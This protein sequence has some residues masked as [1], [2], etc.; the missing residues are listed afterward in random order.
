MIV[1]NNIN[2][3]HFEINGVQYAKIYQPLKQGDNAIGI[4][5]VNDTKQQLISGT[6]YDEFII[7]GVT[8]TN[9]EDTVEALLNLV[10]DFVLPS[11]V[12]AQI[13]DL[14]DSIDSININSIKTYQTLSDLNASTGNTLN[15]SAIVAN[16]STD[17]NNGYYGYN[18]SSWIKNADLYE[19]TID[20]SNTSKGVTGKAVTFFEDTIINKGNE[21][22]GNGVD[23][24]ADATWIDGILRDDGSITN[25]GGGFSF[26]TDEFYE[27]VPSVTRLKFR[28]F[29]SFVTEPVIYGYSKDKSVHAPLMVS[30]NDNNY[31]LTY[32]EIVPDWVYFVRFAT[33]T[34]SSCDFIEIQSNDDYNKSLF[35][36][37]ERRINRENY[38][39]LG[40]QKEHFRTD[41]STPIGTYLGTGFLPAKAG[42]KISYKGYG[43]SVV[44]CIGLFDENKTYI[45]TLLASSEKDTIYNLEIDKNDT[46]VAFIVASHHINGDP[47]DPF[48]IIESSITIDEE[49][50]KLKRDTF[51]TRFRDYY[52]DSEIVPF[53]GNSVVTEENGDTILSLNTDSVGAFAFLPLTPKQNTFSNFLTTVEIELTE[54]TGGSTDVLVETN[55]PQIDNDDLDHLFTTVGEKYTFILFQGIYSTA[56][57]RWFDSGAKFKVVSSHSCWVEN[58]FFNKFSLEEFYDL[59][60]KID[61]TDRYFN[62]SDYALNAKT[63]ERLTSLLLQNNR[64]V[65]FGDSI[66]NGDGSHG[67]DYIDYVSDYFGMS[68]TNLGVW[69]SQPVNNLNDANLAN[70]PSDATVITIAGGTNQSISL[71]YGDVTSRDRSTPQGILNYAIDY[72]ETNHPAAIIILVTPPHRTV[73]AIR[74]VGWGEVYRDVAEYRNLLVADI[75]EKINWT[76]NNIGDFLYDYTHPSD[77]GAKRFAG[78]VV[79]TLRNLIV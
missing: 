48:L 49:I 75:Q 41:G 65:C 21:N 74:N 39:D 25:L 54:L 26:Y 46:D 45:K 70:I 31:V 44:G 57:I 13:D 53:N 77:Y 16:D 15:D 12:S 17:S 51:Y 37:S 11:S 34:P 19:N 24:K 71:P 22:S 32:N 20:E 67:K 58:T 36:S 38:F 59:V 55:G 52:N 47:T 43:V 23:V 28:G 56:G 7:D 64:I 30:V 60:Q 9:Q 61:F 66:T 10:F 27:V 8:Y 2:D 72:I 14:Q 69:G 78:I 50:D 79:G 62:I 6:P 42:D 68:Y 33:K 40:K 73:N 4:Y 3:K 5:N 35:I 1:I 63:S 18:G 29:G 76:T